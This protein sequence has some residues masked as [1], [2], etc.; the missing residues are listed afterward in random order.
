M[1][2]TDSLSRRRVPSQAN[3]RGA[4]YALSLLLA[5]Q[6]P[7]LA[8]AAT[9]VVTSTASNRGTFTEL[10]C[11]PPGSDVDAGPGATTVTGGATLA[12]AQADGVVTLRE[13]ICVANNTAE[14]VVIV[15]SQA[16]YT[17][18]TADNYWYGPNGLPPIGN[19]ITIEG[20]GAVI[21]RNPGNSDISLSTRFRFF[22]VSRKTLTDGIAIVGGADRATL[23]LRDLTLRNG[24]AR[25]GDA[26]AGGAGGG[27]GGAI[28]NQGRLDLQRV[29]FIGNTARGGS[30][31]DSTFIATGPG[32]GM[33]RDGFSGGGFGPGLFG[34][35]LGG[36]TLFDA[37]AQ[38]FKYGCGG[39]AGFGT[40]PGGNAALRETSP[41]ASSIFSGAGGGLGNVGGTIPSICVNGDPTDCAGEGRDGG[42]GGAG[43]SD[44]TTGNGQGGRFGANGSSASD[45]GGGGGVGAGGAEAGISTGLMGGAGGFGGGGGSRTV[46]LSGAS[47]LTLGGAGGF[48]GGGGSGYNPDGDQFGVNG[49]GG[50]GAGDGGLAF[51]IASGGGGAGLGGALFNHGGIVTAVNTTWTDNR[52]IGGSVNV[53]NLARPGAGYGG[54]IFNLDGTLEVSFSTLSGNRVA[55]GSAS[56]ASIPN[57]AGGAIYNRVQNPAIYGFMSRVT[58]RASILANSVNGA[59]APISDCNHSAHPDAGAVSSQL[60]SA[61][62]NLIETLATV[63]DFGS[64]D[65][66][67]LGTDGLLADPQLQELADNGGLTPTMALGPGSPAF[68][69]AGAC[70]QPPTD[71]RGLNRPQGQSCDIG[72]FEREFVC[73]PGGVRR[74]DAQAA[75]GGDGAS[76]ATALADL[77]DALSDPAACEVWVAAGVYKPTSDPGDRLARFALRSTLAVYGGFAGTE[78]AREQRDHRVNVTVLSGDIDGNDNADANGVVQSAADA[79]GANSYRVVEAGAVNASALL[80]GFAITAGMADAASGANRAG[81][82]M[83]VGVGGT[84]TLRNLDFV[85]NRAVFVGA[86]L[87]V[88]GSAELTDVRFRGNAGGDGAGMFN[89][90]ASPRLTNVAFSGNSGNA[91]AGLMVFGGSPVLTNVSFSGNAASASGGAIF[92][93]LSGQPVIRNAV[94]WNNRDASG[95][96]TRASSISSGSGSVAH[97]SASLVQGCKPGGTWVGACGTDLGGNL[98][99]ADPQFFAMPS[100]VAAP[101]AAGDLRLRARSPAV[102]AGNGAD[103]ATALDLAGNARLFGPAIDLGAYEN[104]YL[105]LGLSVAGSGSGSAALVSPLP[106]RFDPGEDVTVAATPASDSDF[107]GWSGDLVAADNP[108]VFAISG[109]TALTANFESK[110]FQV[111]ASAS[112]QGS[113]TPAS[114][115]VV[116]GGTASFTVVPAASWS[117]VAVSGDTCTPEDQGGGSWTASNIIQDCTVLAS[118]TAVAADLQVAKDSGVDTALDGQ[119][120]VYAITVAN[121]GPA[122]V[123]GA[124]LSD[125]LP[126]TL[127]DAEWVCLPA[128]SNTAC[129]PA[130]FDAG[131]GDLYAE[132]DLPVDGFLRYD[133]SARVQADGATLVSNTATVT[134]PADID[135]INPGNNSATSDTLIVPEGIFASDFEAGPSALTVPAAAKAQREAAGR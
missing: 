76:W 78:T 87:F 13:A 67:A 29:S 27:M 79:V 114:Q 85:G 24:F 43:F 44:S 74:V 68:D 61:S 37:S 106:G 54:A 36:S 65:A 35:G 126:S 107:S 80:D 92:N 134:A 48:G 38:I 1:M 94:L 128:E 2:L 116:I 57:P 28:F 112:G 119:V 47:T 118:F 132:V 52:A 124:Q 101:S 7:A 123:F 110:T 99:D 135:D 16:T 66:C 105:G 117:L 53:Q 5:A 46:G 23:T 51:G 58:V 130:P 88:S 97:F 17:L 102:D 3:K 131:S 104:P 89:D 73:E 133:L 34:G 113:I 86:G 45:C 70:T 62:S 40:A 93:T 31:G 33:G 84:P 59:N 55:R 127:V 25:G 26:H 15:L 75:P 30:T 21:E 121:A 100:P 32:G 60:F 90:L 103:N 108:L 19:D 125:I 18:T 129:P 64:H 81:A 96:G 77:Q 98:A 122:A 63:T 22:L 83:R 56:T 111:S 120:L 69:A 11:L 109:D 20:N 10:Q 39:G 50:F 8:Q 49:P 6:L 115:T 12:A 72:A 42:G 91:G 95:T 71:Q 14:P 9:I 82:G 4:R 41:V